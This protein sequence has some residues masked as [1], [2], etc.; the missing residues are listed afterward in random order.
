M[1]VQLVALACLAGAGVI[2][3]GS[4]RLRLGWPLVVLALLLAAI[5]AQLFLA[6]RGQGGFHDLGALVA[7]SYVT[8]PALLGVVVGLL[9]ARIYGQGLRWRSL[10]GAATALGLA[11]AALAVAAT[12]RL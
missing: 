4:A 11:I 7:Q 2:A 5:S 10:S 8:S 3:F 6:A 1:R 12:F 9:L